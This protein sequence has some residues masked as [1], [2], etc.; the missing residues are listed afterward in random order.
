MTV[1][2]RVS[3]FNCEPL[4]TKLQVTEHPDNGR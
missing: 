1:N 2:T 4:P 3:V